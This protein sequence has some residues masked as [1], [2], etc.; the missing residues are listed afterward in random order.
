MQTADTRGFEAAAWLRDC[1]RRH[2]DARG[3]EG[4]PE[5]HRLW[6]VLDGGVG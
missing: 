5:D 4:S 3:G 2:R 1:I 6:S